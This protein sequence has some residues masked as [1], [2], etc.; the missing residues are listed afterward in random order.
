MIFYCNSGNVLIRFTCMR[1]NGATL[2]D[3]NKQ[4]ELLAETRL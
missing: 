4:W 1:N 3:V 2:R